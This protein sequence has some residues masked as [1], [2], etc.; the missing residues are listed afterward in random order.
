MNNKVSLHSPVCD[1]CSSME[2]HYAF[3]VNLKR[4]LR[5]VRCGFIFIDRR[6]RNQSS[7]LV[8]DGSEGCSDEVV[9]DLEPRF[10]KLVI[11]RFLDLLVSNGGKAS[12]SLIQ[13]GCGNG[14]FL[15]EAASRGFTVT[16]L[17]NSHAECEIARK[18][19]SRYGGEII[20][21]QISDV[22][23][24]NGCFDYLVFLNILES[25]QDPRLFVQMAYELLKPNG[26]ILCLV[27]TVDTSLN[28]VTVTEWKKFG[29]KNLSC[30][31]KSSLR[32]LIF[33]ENFSYIKNFSLN[34]AF[35][36]NTNFGAKL[37]E[38]INCTLVT[39]KKFSPL[40]SF[41]PS[42]YAQQVE[43]G[44]VAEKSRK[45]ETRRLTVIMPVFNEA[46]TVR[47]GIERVLLK[48]ISGIDIDLI[49][50]ESNSND[51]TRDV[52]KDYLSNSRVTVIFEA[53][54]KGKGHAVRNGLKAATGDFI[55]IQDGDDEYDIEDYD[56]L[57]EP[58]RDGR[59]VFV[60]GARHGGGG[61][62]MRSFSDQP[63]RAF[64][65]NMGHWVFTGLVNLFY[66]V[67]LRDPFT[68]YKVFRRDCIDGIEFECNRFDFDYELLIKLIRRGFIPVEIPVNYRSRSFL[69][70]KKV[71][72]FADPITWIKAIVK[73]RFVKI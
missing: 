33:Q 47:A 39:P 7:V 19:V 70:G 16:G 37:D 28:K 29:L 52:V 44:V 58:L 26:R 17:N 72:I 21:G 73:Y 25:V 65:L 8:Y 42:S 40:K 14:E 69:E 49:L 55:L 11:N 24:Y 56:A 15:A 59:Q 60:L 43:I 68:M 9:N 34:T 53:E 50:I 41:M 63:F 27:S 12:G 22:I 71:R 67:W 30:F 35:I 5:C 23:N 45:S 64:V 10:K 6:N 13:V 62:K 20:Q 3:S 51:G 18:N 57:I 1:I 31:D 66:G 46:N 38:N 61:W 48:Q 32:S 54:P 2:I 4:V 36:K